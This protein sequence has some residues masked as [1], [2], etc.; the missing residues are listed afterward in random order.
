MHIKLW[1]YACTHL[2]LSCLPDELTFYHYEIFLLISDIFFVLK[3]TVP[4]TTIAMGYLASFP[5]N[6]PLLY[7]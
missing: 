7:I 1:D 6:P 3:S 5:F 4:D 2:E